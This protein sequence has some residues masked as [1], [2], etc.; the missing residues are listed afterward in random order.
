MRYWFLSLAVFFLARPL[1]AQE[2]S[3]GS[4]CVPSKDM[5][6][7]IE[8]LKEKKCLQETTP[9][10][11]LDPI[12]IIVDQ[13]GRIFYSGAEPNPYTLKMTWC[14]YEVQAEGK[15][16]VVAAMKEPSIW[17][18]R[19]RPKAYLGY[20]PLQPLTYNTVAEDGIDAG[21]MLDFFHF[22]FVNA[23]VAVGFRST[24]LGFGIDITKNFGFAASYA[25]T[26]ESWRSNLLTSATFAF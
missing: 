15:V 23:N 9:E 6:V 21:L 2:C 25:V 10:F 20:L 8:I 7:F 19:F 1:A 26:W 24:G 12:T 18:F 14:T 4:T 3:S 5:A 13:D 17:G 22:H 11:Q 16:K